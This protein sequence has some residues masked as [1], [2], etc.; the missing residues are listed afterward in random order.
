[1]PDYS[2]YE[3]YEDDIGLDSDEDK[4]FIKSGNQDWFKG[5]KGRTYRVAF[6]YFHPLDV[7]AV[8]AAKKKNP[9]ITDEEIE[10]L[11]QK[12]LSKRAEEVGKPVDQLADHEKLDLRRVQFKRIRAHFKEGFG[13][14]VSR[15]GKDGK[16]ADRIWEQ[17]G[18]PR[19]YFST[20]LLIYPTDRDGDV[21]K[22]ELSKGKGWVVNPWRFSGK[23]AERVMS[24][25]KSLRNN[26]LSLAAQDLTMKCTN[27]EYQ[28]F[29]LDPAGKAIWLQSPKFRSKVLEAALKLYSKMNPFREMS[30][31]DVRIKLGISDGDVGESVDEEDWSGMLG[32][33]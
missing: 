23:V 1:M 19:D 8:M 21:D 28:N 13:Y 4:K 29:D 26:D 25:G 6:V 33:V 7:V 27:S 3:E 16:D 17:L 12:V 11:V 9:E 2:E 14:V 32:N 15:L 18:E 30:T 5:D 10:K 24:L 22:A 20:L 31:A